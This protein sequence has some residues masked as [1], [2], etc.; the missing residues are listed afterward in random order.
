M[1]EAAPVRYC[2]NCH[3]ARPTTETLC[4]NVVDGVRCDWFLADEP[5]V[6]VSSVE[7]ASPLTSTPEEGASVCLNG[8]PL[9]QGDEICTVC[10]ADRMTA[11]GANA[12]TTAPAPAQEQPVVVLDIASLSDIRRRD[13]HDA[14]ETFTARHASGRDV[15]LTLYAIGAEPDPA[16][17]SILRRMPPDHVP[18]LVETGRFEGRSFEITELIGG[19]SLRQ[20]GL[21]G[22][23]PTAVHCIVSELWKALA[24][25][26]ELGLRHRDLNPDTI[27]L[28]T[29]EPLDLVVTSFGSARLSDFDLDAVS[30]LELTRYSAPEAIV[31]A[32]SSAS[33]WW[34]LGMILLEQ[35]TAGRCFDGTNDLAF[36][37]HVV[38]RGVDLPDGLDTRVRVLLKG[39]LTR[40]AHRRWATKEV[41]AWLEGAEF[42]DEGDG[43]R[44]TVPAGGPSIA[45]TGRSFTQPEMLALEAA[46][47]ANW[48][49]ALALLGRGEIATWLAAGK[50]AGLL[51][52]IRRLGGIEGLS[53]D[54]RLSLSLM[55]MN[56]ALP[57]VVRGDIVTPAWLLANPDAG[58]ELI[59]GEVVRQLKRMDRE[60]W[61]VGL[62]GRAELVRDRARLL[63][64]ELDESRVRPALLSTSRANLEAERDT[65][66]MVYPDSDHGGL[67]SIIERLRVSDEDLIVLVGAAQ[68]QFTPLATLL[69]MTQDLAGKVGVS[70]DETAARDLLVKS[71]RSIFDLIDG[72]TADFAR[73]GNIRVD[74]WVDAFRVE[75]RIALPRAA[76]VMALPAASWQKPPKQQYVA[77]LLGHFE[78]RVTGTVSRGPLARFVI[79]KTTPRID[80]SELGGALRTAE[81]LLNHVL[82]R[83]D[84]PMTI[85]PATY[86][87][88]E[89]RG[90]RLR[91]LINHAATFRRDSGLDGRTLGFPFLVVRDAKVANGEARPRIAPILLWPVALDMSAAAGV[92]LSF[93]RER[94]EVR[95]NPALEAMVP[96][97]QIDKW[98]EALDDALRRN[99]IKYSDVV[100]I[101][102][103]LAPP[104]SRTL[105]RVLSKDAKVPTGTF[106]LHPSAALFNAEFTGQSV[107]EDLRQMIRMPPGGTSLDAA[108]R[109]SNAGPQELAEPDGH[110]R[111]LVIDS[112]PSQNL[113]LGLSRNAPGLLVEGPPGTGK[114]QTI[115]NVVADAIGREETVLIVCQKQAALQVV[116][117]RLDAEGLGNRLVLVTDTNRDREPIVKAIREQRDNLRAASPDALSKLRRQRDG[118]LG[119]LGQLESEID[120]IHQSLYRGD[121][122]TGV[123]YR[124]ILAALIGLEERGPW[125]SV[126]EL[127]RMVGA[128]STSQLA[129]TEETVGPLSSTWLQAGYE[130]SPLAVLK[131]FSVDPST[132]DLVRR[133]LFGVIEADR[134][135]KEAIAGTAPSAEINDTDAAET[136][137][138][139]LVDRLDRLPSSRDSY[140]RAWATLFIADS[141]GASAGTELI[142]KLQALGPTI[143]AVPT[144]WGDAP[145]HASIRELPDEELELKLQDARRYVEGTSL[146][147]RL[148]PTYWSR[149]RRVRRHAKT[150]GVRADRPSVSKLADALELETRLRRITAQINAISQQLGLPAVGVKG[151]AATMAYVEAVLTV[152]AEVRDFSSVLA[153]S[154]WADAAMA[155]T[156]GDFRQDL[157]VLCEQMS[158]AV[159][160][161]VT[162]AACRAAVHNTGAW[163]NDEWVTASGK[164]IDAGGNRDLVVAAVIDAL[165]SLSAYQRFRARAAS[166]PTETLQ[167]FA[168]LRSHQRE[169]QAIPPGEL[170]HLLRRTLQREALLHAKADFESKAPELFVEASERERKVSSLAQLSSELLDLNRQLLRS[171]VDAA[172]LGTTTAW[173]DLT[174]LRGPRARRLRE[175]LDQGRDIGLMRMQP[176]WLMNPDVASRILPL[177]AGLFDLA[178][179]DE[180]SQM[181]VEFAV[182]T[183]FRA[184]RVLIAG[185][186]KQ[187]PPTS[188][189]ASRIDE[190]EDSEGGDAENIEGATEA[191]QLALEETWNRREVK[192]CP[193]LLQLARGVVPTSTLQIHY[194]SKYRELIDYSNAAFYRGELSV[195]VQHPEAEIQKARPIEVVAVNGI[196]ESQINKQ[197]AHEIVG[198][199]ERLW[200]SPSPPTVGVVSFNRKQADLIEET[201]QERAAADAD[202]DLCYRRELGRTREG[203]DMGFFV[204]NVENV[205]GD[206]RDVI[207]FSTTFGRDRNGAFRRNFGV[208]GQGGGERRLNVAVT[209]AREKIILVTSMP[210]S[211]VSDWLTAG[212]TPDKPLDFLQAYLDYARRVSAG[213][214]SA[215]EIARKRLGGARSNERATGNVENDGFVEAVG[216]LIADEGFEP[217]QPAQRD[218]FS[219]DFAVVDPRTGRYGIGIECDSPTH[220]LL[221]RA[222]DREVWRPR[223]LRG[224]VPQVHRVSS[225]N[226]YQDPEGEKEKLRSALRT[227]LGRREVA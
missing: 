168:A 201:I 206:E 189:F 126:P 17:Q 28:R 164:A 53:D 191:E 38:T 48:N 3:S 31:G 188:F 114:S 55:A 221:R 125:I 77:T 27:A 203:E 106:E 176:V 194:R 154:P 127:R 130:Q 136:W 169:L 12:P 11:P 220:T 212:R 145:T 69:S 36:R 137:M 60:P 13:A 64:I 157:A 21:L 179:F 160:R 195:P 185:D 133:A 97:G 1:S 128:L 129:A 54:Y 30:T 187:M 118:V 150:V 90:S 59:T 45:F 92:T 198:I 122:E 109:I 215:V 140:V 197:E 98:R 72:R 40:D 7:A 175:V 39:L 22:A 58:Y 2:P 99:S 83:T 219:L 100:D 167:I 18:E 101:F 46:L 180:A 121:P 177:K 174:R 156:A 147:G 162:R 193:D 14:F 26:E 43:D 37:L 50:N 202:F 23:G 78:K 115:V 67:A 146:F 178:I 222:R 170:D 34:S 142:A 19:G 104:K 32:V 94:E 5:I 159:R 44:P 196:Y 42:E 105:E 143:D 139:R 24:S 226:W 117:K 81:Q 93:D 61:L 208:L 85:D 205:Q 71:R 88:D 138:A 96:P 213:D 217:I 116:R 184:K 8:H 183:L 15:L 111:H 73:S 218:A 227:S 131:Q 134:E 158:G 211:D 120:A 65:I 123:S 62:G 95:L 87:G 75:R 224:Q 68:N 51:S 76:L 124:G 223:V 216:R 86:T 186:E 6:P 207:V 148:L 119:R 33:D 29:S 190:D 199:L 132:T 149:R 112:D 110:D 80:L 74:E 49:D 20:A 153:D 82:A 214:L 113:A 200:S 79:G 209:R 41:G 172:A 4:Q 89:N 152:L 173:D 47:A 70:Y 192:D 102:A 63:E 151:L 107:A 25:F 225:Q 144:E 91:R 204:K 171:N 135:R 182:P 57:M 52:E 84:G 141:E 16:V 108:L 155:A 56:P 66:R 181:P 210:V 161:S 9:A 166:L 163:M 165:P 103:A 10:G 35:V